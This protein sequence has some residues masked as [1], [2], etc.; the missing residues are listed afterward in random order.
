IGSFR[1][2]GLVQRHQVSS[3]FVEKPSDELSAGQSVRVLVGDVDE[4]KQRFS[5]DLRPS[6]ASAADAPLLAREAVALRTLLE[7]R[8]ALATTSLGSKAAKKRFSLLAPGSVLDAVVTEVKNFG[9]LLS[10]PFREG[11]T[12]VCLKENMPES[13]R[14]QAGASIKCA[15]LDFD[16]ESGIADV[17]LQPE[18][19]GVASTSS[20][21]AS[22]GQKRKKKDSD[23]SQAQP[24]VLHVGL[25][26]SVL[27]ALQKQTYSVLWC[28]DPPCVVFAPPFGSKSWAEPRPT[29]VQSVPDADSCGEAA[30]VVVLC[31]QGSREKKE[32]KVKVPR[33]LRPEEELQVGSPIKMRIRAIHGL[34]VFCTAPVGLR[35]HVHAS[36]F[37]DLGAVGSG[38]E[39]PLE[40]MRKTGV[41]EARVLRMQQRAAGVED[42]E[43]HGG[44]VWHLELTCRPK[45]MEPQ[46]ASEYESE[47]VRW[48]SLKPGR[49]IAAAVLSVQKNMLWFE[50]APGIKGRV[51][52]LDASAVQSVVRSLAEN[53]HVGQVFQTR[54]LRTVSSQKE[55]DLSLLPEVAENGGKQNKGK[56]QVILAKLQKVEE[57]VGGKGM[58]ASF[59]L[60]ERKR[61]TAHITELF[62]VW[63]KQPLK[64]LKVGTIYEVVLLRDWN[65]DAPGL[66]GRAEV[67]LRPS[68]VHGQKESEEEKRPLSTKDLMVGQKVSGYVINSGPA[69]VFVGLSRS[70]VA[71]IKLKSI[72]DRPVLKEAVA[73]LH[74][75]GSLIRDAMVVEVDHEK[76]L[77]E[78]SLRSGQGPGSI[79]VEQLSVGDVVSGRVKAVQAF[80]IFVRLDNSNVD[81]LVHKTEVSDSASISMDSYQVGAKIAKAKVLKID[82]KRVSLSLKASSFELDE[83]EEDDED[84]DEDE[85][86]DEDLTLAPPPEKSKP[87]A[88]RKREEAEKADA[89]EDAEQEEEEASKAAKK[90]KKVA[91]VID[92]DDEEPWKRKSGLA[93]TSD[94]T[95]FDFADF[96]VDD[97]SSSDEEAGG[98]EDEEGETKKP[99]KRQKKA[100]KLAEE[101]DLQQREAE[102]ADG[103]WADDPKSTEDFERLLLTQGD[104]SIVWIRYM[105]FH[106][107]MSDLVKA[108]Q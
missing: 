57:K 73:Q 21:V 92:S 89:E 14:T 9:L 35:G 67:S 77:V 103:Q 95:G 105:A 87:D 91:A 71:R 36:Q 47:V 43:S 66:E 31:P 11:L 96:K 54:V 12:A 48:S 59:R 45:L 85:D 15:V 46:D 26:I 90:A 40:G 50:V 33:I 25:Q 70:L 68:L 63:A 98:D 69:G 72:S 107:K 20:S 52:M 32:G 82:G 18:L 106:L 65:E 76:G 100:K 37:L 81:A 78:L 17:S 29:T 1:L 27:P 75:S 97:P 60:P 38:G 55:L 23:D 39:S 56:P 88:K 13:F 61:A 4:E 93:G 34:Q 28:K 62:D 101:K 99:S 42:T 104:T 16:P 79:S 49:L 5:G 102:N 108:R 41:I 58:V 24:A 84:D 10:L 30:R 64:R 80:G 19:L 6:A 22:G 51:S 86:E 7:Q 3:K 83:L 74:P 8:E 2:G 44:K 94:G 53:F